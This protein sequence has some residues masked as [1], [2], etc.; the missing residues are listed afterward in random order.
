MK[1]NLRGCASARGSLYAAGAL[2]AALCAASHATA[3]EPDIPRIQ[4]RA[5]RGS[6]Q[7]E[8][9]LASAYFAGHGV[10]RDEMQAAYW[11]V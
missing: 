6:I 1:C 2:V 5:E 3:V 7:Q 9:E 4:A 10:N 11:Y 8:I